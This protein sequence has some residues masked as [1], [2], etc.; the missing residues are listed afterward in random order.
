M[1]AETFIIVSLSLVLLIFWGIWHS[2]DNELKA[3]RGYKS[4]GD[5]RPDQERKLLDEGLNDSW[6]KQ[7]SHD[8][9]RSAGYVVY[10]AWFLRTEKK[11]C[12]YRGIGENQYP[13]DWKWRKGFVLLRDSFKCR[14]C[15]IGVDEGLLFDCHH[16]VPISDYP[17]DKPGIHGIQNLLTLCAV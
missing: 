8:I 12:D 3:L 16:I 14:D 13:P 1:S 17:L 2:Q 9:A 5:A 10:L 4:R 15:G 6:M 11:Y 7:K